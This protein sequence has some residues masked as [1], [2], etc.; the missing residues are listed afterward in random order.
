MTHNRGFTLCTIHVL[1]TKTNLNKISI[2][3]FHFFFKRDSRGLHKLNLGGRLMQNSKEV[4]PFY[5]K[6]LKL[7]PIWI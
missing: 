2:V 7:L 1:N 4:F 5:F 6:M 3:L